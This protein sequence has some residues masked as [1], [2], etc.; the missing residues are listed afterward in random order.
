MEKISIILPVYNGEATLPGMVRAVLA[1]S[2][3]NWELLLVDDGSA[4]GT[5]AVCDSFAAAD[6]RVRVFH[7]PHRGVSAARNL[8]LAQAAGE[9]IAFLDAD[10]LVLPEY[11]GVLH[12][13]I[14]EHGIALCDVVSLRRG[15]ETGRFTLPGVVLTRREALSLLLQRQKISTGP[16]GKLFR[17]ETVAGLEFP[18][19]AVYEDILFVREAFSRTNRVAVTDRTQYRYLQNP[20][21]TM[22]RFGSEQAADLL[23]ATRELLE[24]QLRED[25]GPLAFYATVSHLLQGTR[26]AG[27]ADSH[28]RARMLLRKYLGYILRCPAF[29]RKERV[30]YLLYAL[31]LWE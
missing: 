31:G 17:R 22:A 12:G 2:H 3:E 30:Y 13:A 18:P 5:G 29:P 19:L 26:A 16:C 9:Y 10:D 28:R 4:D 24:F 15:R 14:G 25:L 6:D 21:G 7:Q 27:D 11:F 8:G 23:R 1:Q 20:A